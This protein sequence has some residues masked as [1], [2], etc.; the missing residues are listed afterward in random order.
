MHL[1]DE[2][3]EIVRLEGVVARKEHPELAA[4]M[5]RLRRQGVLVS[6]LP[7]VYAPVAVAAQHD[8]RL[9]A[10]VR[11]A[12]DAVLLG[13]TAA[14]LTFWPTLPAHD[15]ECALPWERDPQPGFSFARRRIAPELVTRRR[16][17]HAT[18]P[19]LTA[20]DLC[21]Q[22]GGDGI[23]RVLRTRTATL[24]VL[25]EAFALSGGRR[26]NGDRRALLL[27]SRGLPWSA[28]E[29]LA[30]RLL[31]DARLGGWRANHPIRLEGQKYFLDIAFRDP[32]LV[33]EI[34]GRLHEEDKDVFENDRWRQ[35]ALVL[36]GWTVLRFTWRMLEDHPGLFVKRVKQAVRS[37]RSAR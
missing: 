33:V 13:G 11:W 16:G 24:P 6:V 27:D 25:W 18:S 4:A 19:A 15:V 3:R 36:D 26:G 32:R 29:R 17:M 8:V 23:D 7:G 35:N 30:H 22:H 9:A 10:L 31:R 37:I 20:L 14:R 1:Q 5:A 12:P 28:A 21:E 34:D 2:V